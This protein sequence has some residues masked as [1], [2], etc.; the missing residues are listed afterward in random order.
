MRRAAEETREAHEEA[1]RRDDYGTITTEIAPIGPF[2]YTE[3]YHQ[4]NVHKVPNGY[5]GLGETG[6]SCPVGIDVNATNNEWSR[7]DQGW[8]ESLSSE[9]YAVLREAATELPFYGEYV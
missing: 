5:C 8:R 3:D 7:T 6:V 9:Q 1:L 2:Y 4:K